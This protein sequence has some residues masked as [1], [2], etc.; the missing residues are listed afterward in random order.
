MLFTLMF[1]WLFLLARKA[2]AVQADQ[3]VDC[4][5]VNRYK[6][7]GSWVAIAVLI[8]LVMLV[9]ASLKFGTPE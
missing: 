6:T 9:L 8:L 7:T 3:C 4:G 5:T 2:F 1:G